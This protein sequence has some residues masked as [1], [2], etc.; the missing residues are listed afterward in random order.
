[1]ALSIIIPF[2]GVS[3]PPTLSNFGIRSARRK[4]LRIFKIIILGIRKK[5]GV[6]I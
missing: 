3:E 6:I 4:V 1:M 2:V 5:T